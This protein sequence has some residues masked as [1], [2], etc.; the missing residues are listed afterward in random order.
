MFSSSTTSCSSRRASH[1]GT[2]SWWAFLSSLN[3][4]ST[5]WRIRMLSRVE[6]SL[7][8]SWNQECQPRFYGETCC[9]SSARSTPRSHSCPGT[10]QVC[11]H[12]RETRRFR[13]KPCRI[14]ILIAQGQ[15]DSRKQLSSK[16]ERRA[17]SSN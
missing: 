4:F 8:S 13:V 15:I 1:S 7:R 5:M 6:S 14:T 10:H 9:G 2:K 3:S 11:L 16:V 12:R 17:S